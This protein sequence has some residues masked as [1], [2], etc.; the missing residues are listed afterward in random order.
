MKRTQISLTDEDRRLLD[1]AAASTGRSLSALIRDAVRARYGARP[2]LDEEEVLSR[3]VG[4]WEDRDFD[5]AEHVD[6]LRSGRRL[7]DVR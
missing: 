4:S 1:A 7:D 3:A 2:D 6:R 5:S